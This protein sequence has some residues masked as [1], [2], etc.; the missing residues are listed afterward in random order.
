MGSRLK[1]LALRNLYAD[2]EELVQVIESLRLVEHITFDNVRLLG[3]DGVINQNNTWFWF[4]HEL[5]SHYDIDHTA[6]KP[7]IT[8]IEPFVE[9]PLET[10]RCR[11]VEEDIG[12][13]LYYGWVC[14]FDEE[15]GLLRPLVGWVVDDRDE[16]FWVR[17]G[18]EYRA[19]F[20]SGVRDD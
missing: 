3:T 11:L 1:T 15:T 12:G 4:L 8:Y 13:F 7:Q 20:G 14:P 16:N 5:K 2:Y 9:V 19:R 18:D 17:A 6:S 10:L